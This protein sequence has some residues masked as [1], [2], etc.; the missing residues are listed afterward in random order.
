MRNS[1]VANDELFHYARQNHSDIA[2]LQEPY[3]RNGRL[4]G[5]EVAPTRIHLSHPTRRPSKTLYG[6]AIVVFSEALRV[7]ALPH[8]L[9]ENLAVVTLETANQ[10]IT[11]ASS[12]FKFCV[13]IV[14]HILQLEDT[15]GKF[16]LPVFIGLDSNA[17]YK[18][19]KKLHG[20]KG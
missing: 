6:A 7:L 13:P 19:G 2:L 3:T 17:H 11:V 18:R 14:H 12:Y 15:I 20:H 10:T 1:S 8:I 5:L 9:K 16:G 4:V